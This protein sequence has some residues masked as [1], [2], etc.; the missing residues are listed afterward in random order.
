MLR[1]QI[2]RIP[3]RVEWYFW[4]TACVLLGTSSVT[5]AVL[6]LW[7]AC[8]FVSIVAHELGHALSAR[9]LGRLSPVVV[10]YGLGGLTFLPG[11]E[12]LGPAR[13]IGITL[14]GPAAGFLLA[15]VVAAIRPSVHAADSVYVRTALNFLL[16]ININWTLF[17]LLP[18]APLDGGQVLATLLGPRRIAITRIVGGSLAGGLCVWALLRQQIFLAFFFGFLAWQNFK[19]QPG[20]PLTTR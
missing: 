10:L 20:V 6:V 11:V 5:P 16:F 3:F 2:F 8:V 1:F 7:V 4:L 12:R 14:A 19:P 18:I 13:R 9:A 17:N 15:A